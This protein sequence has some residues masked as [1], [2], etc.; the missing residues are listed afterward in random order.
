[1]KYARYISLIALSLM[2]GCTSVTSDRACFAHRPS[3]VLPNR[4]LA[5]SNLSGGAAARSLGEA[6]WNGDVR[7]A[8]RMIRADPKLLGASVGYDTRMAAPPVGQYGD[9]LAF[10]VSRCDMAMIDL[11]LNSGMPADGIQKGEAMAIAL[12]A[13]SPAMADKLFDAGAS[14]DPQKNGGKNLVH[15]LSAFSAVGGIQTL[16]RRGLDLNWV[17]AQGNDHLDTALAMEQYSIAEHLV[18]AG[19]KLWRINGAGALNAWT[20]NKPMVLEADRE[21]LAARERLLVLAKVD[22][23]PN[24]P[25]DPATV[26]KFVLAKS[27]PTS[28][29]AKAGMVLSAQAEADIRSRFGNEQK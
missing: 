22:G 1:M 21:N 15:E 26:R 2:P 4:Q 27:W 20:L 16:I 10:A 12:L 11:L 7:E 25:P 17:D 18:R 19:A 24:P 5:L 3:L 9:M 28:A 13:N 8:E 29:M 14:P 6:V 23:L